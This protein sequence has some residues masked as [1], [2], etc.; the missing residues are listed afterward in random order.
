MQTT[1]AT[2]LVASPG[3]WRDW[4]SPLERSAELL[5][6]LPSAEQLAFG[7]LLHP[8]DL[9]DLRDRARISRVLSLLELDAGV[10]P[11]KLG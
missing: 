1:P 10:L 9:A 3:S 7:S 6:A 4:L 5:T 11:H 8:P 2:A